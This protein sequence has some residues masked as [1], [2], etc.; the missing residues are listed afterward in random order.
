MSNGAKAKQC[1][2]GELLESY[3]NNKGS[4]EA[5]EI[6]K[7]ALSLCN[8]I[9]NFHKGDFFIINRDLSPRSIIVMKNKEAKLVDKKSDL[10]M[11]HSKNANL[12]YHRLW[13]AS[14]Q[15]DLHSLAML[16]YFMATGTT[17]YSVLDIFKDDSYPDNVDRSLKEIMHRCFE[18]SDQN[19]Y[20]SVEELSME[21]TM[22]ILENN[23]Y[24]E[25]VNLINSKIETGISR[26]RV[27]KRRANRAFSYNEG[28]DYVKYFVKRG[29]KRLQISLRL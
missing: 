13:E 2:T 6:Y 15:H 20:S 18:E 7:I 14:K 27:R 17:A 3:V 25:T 28:L 12:Q 22:R 21:I 4:L 24:K 8:I 19:K 16:M 11:F 10:R 23:R 26:R 5:N 1:A 29:K 9:E